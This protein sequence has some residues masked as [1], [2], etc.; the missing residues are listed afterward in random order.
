MINRLLNLPLE[1]PYSLFLFGPR[2]TGKTYWL[3]KHLPNSL[4]FDLLKS[5]VYGRLRANPS[6]L[7]QLIPSDY[8]DWIILDEVQKIPELLN[9]VHRLIELKRYKFILTGSSARSLRKKGTNLLAGRALVYHM[10]PLTAQELGD[11][12][13][14]RRA[15]EFGLLPSTITH[16]H[17]EQYLES[18]IFAYLKEEVGQEGLTRNLEIFA[19]FL[20]IASFSQGEMLNMSEIARELDIS[21]QTVSSY[22]TI[23]EDLLLSVRIKPFTKRAKRRM[24]THKKFYYFDVGVFKAVRP[25]GPLD[26]SK[27]SDGAG[28][29]TLFLQSVRAIN[30]YYNLGYDIYYWRTA[31]GAEVDFILYGKK[32]FHAF[33][34]KRRGLVTNELLSGLKKFQADYP[35]AQLHLLYGGD[36]HEYHGSITAR[37]MTDA[38]LNLP[39]ILGVE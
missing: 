1:D 28:L 14:I 24:V 2:G 16:K 11:E 15:L 12:F 4:Y 34:I 19:D 8:K 6:R 18:Y 23:L 32:G 31:A 10:H 35:E 29:E 30:D 26:T 39:K 36:H 7:E 22:F 38:L 33:E 25:M 27:E 21:R 17:P 5:S 13:N 9:E 20:E 37:P 3:K